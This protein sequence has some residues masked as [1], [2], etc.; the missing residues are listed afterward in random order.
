M[1]CFH[2]PLIKMV[3][4]ETGEEYRQAVR[5]GRCDGCLLHRSRQWAVRCMHEASLYDANAFVTLT[6]AP[7]FL[8]FD[9]SLDPEA[10][11]K[12]MKRLR[13][14]IEPTRVRFFGCGE[15]GEMYGRPH[16]HLLLFGYGFP[17][18][19]FLRERTGLPVYRSRLLECVWPYGLSEIGS[20]TYESAA[21]VARYV[22]KK[23][24]GANADEFYTRVSADTGEVFQVEKEFVRM[25]RREGLGAKWLDRYWSDV[26][27]SDE[28]I[29][30][31]KA[32]KP[33]RFYDDRFERLSPEMVAR[34]KET[35]RLERDRRD[36]GEERLHV[37]EMCAK[38][39]VKLF[40]RGLE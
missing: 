40:P 13:R 33:P 1:R 34:V 19:E 28:V 6:Y 29:V 31:G 21:Y 15:Y 4:E 32:M 25:S 16:Y 7:E 36:D 17:D 37:L 27:P 9:G 2:P 14:R 35:R 38:A 23:R 24:F 39:R 3:S 10:L 8:P 30:N 26:Y 11:Q 20:V 22:L 18:K 5:C 12:F